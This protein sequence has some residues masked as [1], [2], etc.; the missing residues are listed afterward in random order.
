MRN[1][2][3]GNPPQPASTLKLPHCSL[4]AAGA[5]SPF[6]FTCCKES[7]SSTCVG[8]DY[9]ANLSLT[10][11]VCRQSLDRDKRHRAQ[12]KAQRPVPEVS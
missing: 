4:D 6:R 9:R 10:H 12:P 8:A 3:A 2:G 5:D 1:I 11:M 7:Y